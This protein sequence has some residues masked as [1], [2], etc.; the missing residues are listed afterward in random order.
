[1]VAE[2]SSRWSKTETEPDYIVHLPFSLFQERHNYFVQLVAR[3]K[4]EE[5]GDYNRIY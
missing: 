4:F 1:M 2:F 3:P 5:D